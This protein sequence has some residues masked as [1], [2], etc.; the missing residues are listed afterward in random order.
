MSV[1]GTEAALL[2]VTTNANSANGR[3]GHGTLCKT[4]TC[5]ATLLMASAPPAG[6]AGRQSCG[7]R[8]W[9]RGRRRDLRRKQR[10]H[11]RTSLSCSGHG[12]GARRA[13]G[14]GRQTGAAQAPA[15]EARGRRGAQAP[16]AHA[17]V[18]LSLIYPRSYALRVSLASL[19]GGYEATPV[20]VYLGGAQNR[21]CAAVPADVPASATA[22][23]DHAS[24]FA[25]S[26]TRLQESKCVRS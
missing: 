19:C 8:G 13:G 24:I 20:Q 15:G 2:V 18:I 1:E 22:K 26:H 11:R 17:K 4:H 7:C 3:P 14:A 10:S 6:P 21:K 5:G 16:A 25:R 12:Q 23:P 9:E